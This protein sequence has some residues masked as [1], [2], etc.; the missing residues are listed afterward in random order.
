MQSPHKCPECKGTGCDPE[1]LQAPDGSNFLFPRCEL[2]K[3]QG[4]LSAQ[5]HQV[6][7]KRQSS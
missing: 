7:L 2:C 5:Q 6:Y 3:G 4:A 1:P